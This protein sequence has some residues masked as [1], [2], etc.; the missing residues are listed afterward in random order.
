MINKKLILIILSAIVILAGFGFVKEASAE[1]YTSGYFI[2]TNLLSGVSPAPTSIDSF[3]YS[4]FA[5]PDN[6]EATVGF[7]QDGSS[8]WYDA[9]GDEGTETLVTG[10]NQTIPLTS[11]WSGADFYYKVIFTSDG[12]GT[13]VLDDITLNYNRAPTITSA[14]ISDRDDTDNLYA[15]NEYYTFTAVVNDADGATDIDKVYLQGKQGAAVRFEVRAIDLTGTPSYAIQTG[16]AI[17]DLDTGNC[18]WSENGNEGTATFEVRFEWDYSPEADCEIAVYVEDSA[19]A[20]AGF[21][22]KQTD[23]WDAINRLVTTSFAVSDSRVN[24][25]GTSGTFSGNVRYATTVSGD[26]ASGSYPPD[27]QFTDVAIHDSSHAEKDTDTAIVNGAFGGISFTIPDAVQSNTY[28][29][30]LD[31][32]ADYTDADAPDGDTVNVIGDRLEVVSVAFD[33]SR[34]DVGANAEARYSFQYDYDD[35]AFDDTKGT[36]TG[37]SWDAGGPWW[38]KAITGSSSVTSTNYD[39]TDISFTDSTY[40]LTAIEDDAGAD[41]VTDRIRILTLSAVDAVISIN[42][43]GTWYVTA[44][45]EYDNH[46]LGSGDSFTLSNYAF[47]WDVADSRFEAA[48]TKSSSQTVTINAF[49]SGS[50]ATY[51]ITAGNINSLSQSIEWQ[52]VGGGGGMPSAWYSPPQAPQGGFGILI[53]NG[54][55]ET[56]NLSVKL[57]LTGGADTARMAISNFSDFQDAGQEQYVSTKEWN[58]CKGLTSCSEGE[59]T[60]YAKFYASWGL[61]S[62]VVSDTIIFKKEKPIVEKIIEEIKKIPEILEPLIPEILKPKPPEEVKPP[63][64]PIEEL[65]PKEAPSVFKGQWILLTYTLKNKPFVKFTLAPLPREFQ[66]LAEKFPELGKTFAEIGVQRLIDIEK[67]RPV[68]L[69]LPGLTERVGLPTAKIEPGK[70]ALPQGIP[71][72]ELSPEVKEQIPTEIVFAKTG[73][74]LIDFNIA[75]SITEKG[76]AKQKITTISGKPLNLAVKPEKPVNS[77]KGYIIFKAK[78]TP[79]ESLQ[80]PTGQAE[81]RV[82]LSLNTLLASLLFAN[83]IFAEEHNPKEIEEV[84]VLMEFEYTD[85]DGDGIYTADIQAPLVEGEYEIITVMDYED[86]DLGQKEIRLIT[87]VDPEGY[88]YEKAGDKETR[89]PGAIISLFW[90]NSETKQYEL[91]PAKEYHQENPQITDTTGKYAFLVPNG[92]YYLKVEAPGYLTYDGRAFQVGESSG[93]HINIELK[94]KYWWLK[95]VDWKTL[96]LI[97][98]ILFLVYNFYRDKIRER[99]L[100]KAAD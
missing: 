33:D 17:I 50:E 24:K 20:S 75:L 12:V 98:V 29:I 58:L 55:S 91:W 41:I 93:I 43:E 52:A 84:L 70:F 46:S 31:L 4:L 30:Y 45:L 7:N 25:G 97:L 63:E 40:G 34:I 36:V 57:S 11:G 23:Y 32:V 89:I 86:P 76:E 72:A 88:V 49:D 22:D 60:V 56:N 14:S 3:V 95:V 9:A 44:E 59:Y 39:E 66:K 15:M 18:G 28:H 79:K 85:P 87:V 47:S 6:T 73:G 67:L 37:F 53:N 90:L 54:A 10:A 96:L 80:L 21:T 5:K 26:T 81:P 83:P 78:K 48:D 64:V 77:I 62:D 8:T 68:K 38:D 94:T 42:A 27:A 71:V 13:P 35:V 99:W 82:E 92:S 16:D 65:V 1:Y 100:K 19:A 61:S 69:T 2:S 74:E 51:G